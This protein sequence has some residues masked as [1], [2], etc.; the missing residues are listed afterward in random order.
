M[1]MEQK[2]VTYLIESYHPRTIVLVGSRGGDDATQ[3]S[4]W[5]LVL[6]VD[7]KT[8]GGLVQFETETLDIVVV[9]LPV[10]N[11]YILKI[12][13]APDPRMKVLLDT[14]DRLGE[15]IVART[16]EWY[17]RGPSPLTKDE[18]Q[19][20][21]Q[22]L[23]RLLQKCDSRPDDEGYVFI[24]VGAF[25]EFA[26]RY[27]FELHGLWS[28]PAYQALAYLKDNAPALYEQFARIHGAT[29]SDVKRDAAKKVYDQL[30]T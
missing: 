11:D 17:A 28:Q 30:F 12:S 13:F 8:E 7:E 3:T 21:K 9:T 19:K 29:T 25:Y 18:Y 5:D 22:K 27:Y 20:R 14:S 23:L 10:P 24:Y 4:D 16:R 15:K 6:F 2:I 1:N 26:L